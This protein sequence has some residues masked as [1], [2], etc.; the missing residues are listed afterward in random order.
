MGME[1]WRAF[2][3]VTELG[4]AE[5]HEWKAL[6]CCAHVLSFSL[7]GFSGQE[8]NPIICFCPLQILK[9]Y[10]FNRNRWLTEKPPVES[11]HISKQIEKV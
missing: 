3:E 2:P 1:G 10:I 11:G 9:C 6:R 4:K 8:K 5:A 7:W